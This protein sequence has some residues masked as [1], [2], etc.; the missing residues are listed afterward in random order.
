MSRKVR[1]AVAGGLGDVQRRKWAAV[2]L[3]E[4]SS[5]MEFSAIADVYDESR[6]RDEKRL[7]DL[8]DELKTKRFKGKLDPRAEV[9]IKTGLLTGSTKYFQIDPSNL[10]L[11]E[12]FFT[13]TDVVDISTPNRFHLDLAKQVIDK[14]KDLIIEKPVSWNVFEAIELERYSQIHPAR[15]AVRV[16]A[17]HYSNYENVRYYIDNF[18]Q[19]VNSLGRVRGIE[20]FIEEDEDFSSIRNGQIIDKTKSGGGILLD[21]GIHTLAFLR[22]IGARIERIV[23]ATPY[24]SHDPN[25][26][27]ERYG[28]TGF[29]MELEL[30]RSPFFLDRTLAK[31]S[32]GKCCQE[33]RKVF[34]MEHERGRVV[35]DIVDKT[36]RFYRGQ[37]LVQ[38]T[39]Y[40]EDAFFKMYEELGECVSK[41]RDPL[42]SMS[43]GIENVKDVGLIY[44][45]AS[46]II[47]L[48]RGE[49]RF[50]YLPR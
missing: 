11:P 18:R 34:Q 40:E 44:S 28:E 37:K 2:Y 16:A 10:F 29:E 41:R 27:D 46:P 1:I 13:E 35:M 39:R 32:V 36:I 50:S 9:F 31:I 47:K 19:I 45:R 23:S 6:V 22:N 21:T 17:D 14:G 26:Q 43:R 42:N 49:H 38:T 20:L 48:S 24:K 7:E 3:T 33:K 4:L 8:F 5:R 12:E 25:I 30:G 15:G